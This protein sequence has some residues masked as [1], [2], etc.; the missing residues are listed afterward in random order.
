M[1]G[2]GRGSSRRK[3]RRW[4]LKARMEGV[5][6]LRREMPSSFSTGI[7]KIFRSSIGTKTNKKKNE[8]TRDLQGHH[9]STAA[10]KAKLASLGQRREW[11]F[12]RD[13]P[14]TGG[15]WR[16]SPEGGPAQL[17]GQ[18]PTAVSRA[19]VL[20]SEPFQGAVHHGAVSPRPQAG[21]VR[22]GVAPLGCCFCLP[23]YELLPLQAYAFEC[24]QEDCVW[25]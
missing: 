6:G 1:A 11:A 9:A 12:C 16:W 23:T 25:C 3:S 18:V 20:G 24:P 2:G 5:R 22:W 21:R 7:W 14:A 4:E 13:V 19:P 8:D 17:R 15:S 10:V